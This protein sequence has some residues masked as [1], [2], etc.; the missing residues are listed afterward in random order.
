[1]A[2]KILT[3]NAIQ[4]TNIDG[5]RA[6]F[7]N[8]GM[9]DGIIK[10]AFNEGNIYSNGSVISF[11]TC[12]LRISGHRIVN[13]S[14]WSFTFETT[15]STNTI[16]SLVANLVVDSSSV[17]TF[18]ILVQ[19]NGTSLTRDNLFLN[20]SGEGTYQVELAQFTLTTSLTITNIQ[21]KIE[22][23]NGSADTTDDVKCL[24][25]YAKQ[26]STYTEPSLN[27]FVGD[28]SLYN[29]ADNRTKINKYIQNPEKYVLYL[30]NSYINKTYILKTFKLQG[31]DYTFE[32]H[33]AIEGN[34]KAREI[35][36]DYFYYGITRTL[37][38]KESYFSLKG[39]SVISITDYT[40]ASS[41]WVDNMQRKSISGKTST[42]HAMVSNSNSGT[43]AE[44][45]LNAQNIADANI[46]KITDNLNGTLTFTCENTPTSDLKI[47]VEVFE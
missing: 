16:Y 35:I 13:D 39:T 9:R 24:V 27:G 14:V 34:D 3:K 17:P 4:N 42:N 11:D 32:F 43:D 2:F 38:Y 30:N 47:Q 10:G 23:I 45:L 6:E 28:F 40:L 8:S 19:P 36:L 41:G 22:L 1:M 44:V 15:P 25:L 46:Y 21:N 37:E 12:E 18:N 29:T 5:A 31:T 26:G 7:F 20:E 33:N